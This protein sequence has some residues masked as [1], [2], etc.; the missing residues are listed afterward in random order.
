M[1]VS[2]KY[3]FTG[4]IAFCTSNYECAGFT[5]KGNSSEPA[6]EV[7]VYF[8]STYEPNTDPLWNTYVKN[9]KEVEL[10]IDPDNVTHTTNPLYL[11]CHSDSGYTHQPRGFYSQLLY[12]ETFQNITGRV[13]P[14]RWN[15]IYEDAQAKI[16]ADAAHPFVSGMPSQLLE[17]ESGG[18]RVGLSNR[19]LGN[20][21]LALSGGK[22]YEGYLFARADKPV[23]LT[24][25][26]EDYTTTAVLASTTLVIKPG[27]WTRYNFSLTPSA[28]TAC[29]TIDVRSD[30]NID[31]GGQG[32]PLTPGHACIKCAGEFAVALGKAGDAVNLGYAMLQPGEW[33][34]YKE[35]CERGGHVSFMRALPA[36]RAGLEVLKS[37]VDIL[38]S[39]GVTVIRQ[40]GTFACAPDNGAYYQWQKWTGPAYKRESVGA[41]WGHS[42]ISGS[43]PPPEPHLA[44]YDW[45]TWRTMIGPPG[46]P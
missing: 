25:S 27:N 20:E 23:N 14:G 39:M 28:G 12:G 26:L 19:G 6:E 34:R 41:E 46:S 15:Q 4:A 36:A 30:P 9:F 42:Y 44:L 10:I 45:A 16:I 29:E 2:G 22:V 32:S 5:F 7:L 35:R 18:G 21:G 1:F 13:G 37:G 24:V 33:G 31:C 43:D 3:N 40:G 8:K 11:G 38:K 17:F